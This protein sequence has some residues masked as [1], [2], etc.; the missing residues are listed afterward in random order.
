MIKTFIG[1]IHVDDQELAIAV[2]EA[3]EMRAS[4]YEIEVYGTANKIDS[5]TMSR[6]HEGR[7]SMKV[8]KIENA[9]A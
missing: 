5:V 8:Y 1:E 3:L 4:N 9:P 2:A 6:N 7:V